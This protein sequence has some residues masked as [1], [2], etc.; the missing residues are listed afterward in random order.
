M[1]AMP[2]MKKYAH[3][4]VLGDEENLLAPFPQEAGKVTV[5]KLNNGM[6][7]AVGYWDP[8]T[9]GIDQVLK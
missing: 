9:Q 5:L 3:R 1:F 2:K 4:I 6:V 7:S 8:A